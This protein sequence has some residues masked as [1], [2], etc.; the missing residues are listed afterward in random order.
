[1]DDCIKLERKVEVYQWDETRRDAQDHYKSRY[2]MREVWS[3][4]KINQSY[5]HN[6]QI[7]NGWA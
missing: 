6:Q 4:T 2:K 7:G 1:M 3:E 5:F